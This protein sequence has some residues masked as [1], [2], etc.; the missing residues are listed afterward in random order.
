MTNDAVLTFRCN[1]ISAAELTLIVG[2]ANYGALGPWCPTE[3]QQYM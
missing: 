2:V 3:F 1:E